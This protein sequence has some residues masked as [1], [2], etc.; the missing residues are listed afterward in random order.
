M[1][2]RNEQRDGERFSLSKVELS[3]DMRRIGHAACLAILSL[4]NEFVMLYEFGQCVCVCTV[5]LWFCSL[6]RFESTPRTSVQCSDLGDG[7]VGIIT[8]ND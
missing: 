6:F 2:E 4:V 8:G 7:T 1:A 5:A 3:H